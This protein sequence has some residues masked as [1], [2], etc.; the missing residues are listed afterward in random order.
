MKDKYGKKGRRTRYRNSDV[1]KSVGLKQ[2]DTTMLLNPQK[3]KKIKLKETVTAEKAGINKMLF[4]AE[5]DRL[6]LT[7]IPQA[8]WC[9]DCFSVSGLYSTNIGGCGELLQ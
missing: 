1:L 5:L 2:I 8:I 7:H 9:S 3:I 6:S 4:L